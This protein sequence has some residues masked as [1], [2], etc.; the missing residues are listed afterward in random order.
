MKQIEQWTRQGGEGEDLCLKARYTLFEGINQVQKKV[1]S[2]GK[3][4]RE[5]MFFFFCFFFFLSDRC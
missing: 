4:Q 2:E 1:I 3:N 5:I